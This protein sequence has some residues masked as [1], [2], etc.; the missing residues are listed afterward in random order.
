M[1]RMT[2]RNMTSGLVSET[3]KEVVNYY[4]LIYMNLDGGVYMTTAPFNIN[5]GGNTYIKNVGILSVG[6]V[7]ENAAFE[8]EKLNV[9][10]YSQSV[11]GGTSNPIILRVLDPNFDYIDKEVKIWRA[12]YNASDLEGVVELYF[13]YVTSM[14]ITSGLTVGESTVSFETSSHWTNFDS[15]SG[16]FTNTQSQALEFSGD[17]GFDYASQ[18]QKQI[19]WK[20][21]I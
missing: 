5:Y 8:I 12:Y 6:N 18:I 10:L 15:T 20:E 4:D 1:E 11:I 3:E 7:V 16:R 14:G 19:S 17:F 21:T 2:D 13:G 9:S